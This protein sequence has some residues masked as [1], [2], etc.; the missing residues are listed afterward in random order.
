[1]ADVE[2]TA[3]TALEEM[4][5]LLGLLRVP[6]TGDGAE[7]AE[8]ADGTAAADTSERQPLQGLADIGAL[9]TRMTAAGLPVTVRATGE[10]RPVPEDVGLT[11]YRIAQEALT[12]VL[13]HAGPARAQVSLHYGGQLE[14]TITDD[15]HGASAALTGPAGPVAPGAGRGTT[16]MRERIAM[17]GGEFT[18]GP[19][20]GGGFCVRATIPHP[21]LTEPESELT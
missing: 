5:R 17:L 19:Q 11:V 7:G 9:A 18:A 12:N 10:P 16:G 21:Y 4:R 6:D 13:K 2:R 8:G 20:P 3:R 1:M 15:G 14:I